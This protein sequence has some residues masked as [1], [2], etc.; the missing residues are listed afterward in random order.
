MI[1]KEVITLLLGAGVLCAL[2]GCTGTDGE[3]AG[4]ITRDVSSEVLEIFEEA[5]TAEYETE[6]ETEDEAEDRTDSDIIEEDESGVKSDKLKKL[7]FVYYGKQYDGEDNPAFD[8]SI[9]DI[10]HAPGGTILVLADDGDLYFTR[11]QGWNDY[12]LCLLK[13]KSGL[14]D[15]KNVTGEYSDFMDVFIIDSENNY[16]KARWIEEDEAFKKCD[17]GKDFDFEG[18][19]ADNFTIFTSGVTSSVHAVDE[20]TGTYYDA[21]F[22]YEN[23]GEKNTYRSENYTELDDKKLWVDQ[24]GNSNYEVPGGLTIVDEKGAW[25]LA[26]DN[27]IYY[28]SPGNTCM[29]TEPFAEID[30]PVSGLYGFIETSWNDYDAL[31]LSDDK[32][33]LYHLKSDGT[34][35]AMYVMPEGDLIDIKAGTYRIIVQTTEGFFTLGLDDETEFAPSEPLNSISNNI[36][37]YT[38]DLIITKD[39]T[40]YL[41]EKVW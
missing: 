16:L 15:L 20:K 24:G 12:T 18:H 1:R 23:N 33:E 8:K 32:K 17:D 21:F 37:T 35:K 13:E 2:T 30:A 29:E 5:S 31:V 38:S 41:Y 36:S 26:S 28:H 19:F 3:N 34:V 22:D 14:K 6:A 25:T 27:R 7:E 39:N 9:S 4:S 11:R 40:V 10:Y